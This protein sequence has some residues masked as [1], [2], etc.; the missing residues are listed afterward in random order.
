MVE[1]ISTDR[2][3]LARER[4]QRKQRTQRRPKTDDGNSKSP[5]KR[6]A[7][8]LRAIPL[9]SGTCLIGIG[10]HTVKCGRTTN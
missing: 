7:Q 6:S 1:K 3:S 4:W 9:P 5:K 10:E 8:A 2:Q